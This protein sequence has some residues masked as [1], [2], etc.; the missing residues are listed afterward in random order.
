MPPPPPPPR[1]PVGGGHDPHVD[2]NDGGAAHPHDLP[3]LQDPEQL[4]LKS[5]THALHLVQKQRALVGDLKQ[6]QAA[7]LLAPVK[8][9]SS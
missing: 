6:A 7:A 5:R 1:N 3:F 4:D 2:G 9:P 8:A